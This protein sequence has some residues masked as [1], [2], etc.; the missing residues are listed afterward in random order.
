MMPA[1]DIMVY[2]VTGT[3]NK[4]ESSCDDATAKQFSSMPLLQSYIE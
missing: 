1:A 2:Y 3:T 4:Y